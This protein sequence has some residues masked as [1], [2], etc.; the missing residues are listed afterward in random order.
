MDK[1]ILSDEVAKK[2]LGDKE[3]DEDLGLIIEE[4]IKIIDVTNNRVILNSRC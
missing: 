3:V 2:M 1:K 4:H